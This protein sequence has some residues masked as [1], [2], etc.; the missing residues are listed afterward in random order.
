MQNT[1][2]LLLFCQLAHSLPYDE[3]HGRGL[4]EEKQVF[5]PYNVSSYLE[6]RQIC[7]DEPWC[8]AYDYKTTTGVCR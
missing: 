4:F 1:F 7:I 6:C 2:Y 8:K 5:T 3:C